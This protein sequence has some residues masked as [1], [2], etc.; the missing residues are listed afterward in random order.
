LL[1]DAENK[2]ALLA[3]AE[4]YKI[5]D[6]FEFV[7][8]CENI[9][10]E[11]ARLDCMG[12]LLNP[13]H[14]GTTENAILET[15]AAGIPIVALNQNTEKYIIKNNVTGFLVNDPS[16]YARVISDLYHNAALRQ[17]IADGARAA[18]KTRFVASENRK[19]L[20]DVYTQTMKFP[21]SSV[22]F[23]DIFGAEPADWF[24]H[25]VGKERELFLRNKLEDVEYIFKAKNKSSILH[26]HKHFPEDKRLSCWKSQVS[27]AE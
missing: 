21:K 9:D 11:L 1:G 25:F 10:R 20:Y 19:N 17:R 2:A 8:F 4:D 13:Y 6:R 5:A 12:Y 27:N 15:M 24:L 18:I 3:Q 16:E 14:F 23:R 26:F 7:G 22:V